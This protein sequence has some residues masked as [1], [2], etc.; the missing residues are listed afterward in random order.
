MMKFEISPP[1]VAAKRILV[2]KGFHAVL[3]HNHISISL[4]AKER[5]GIRAQMYL[6][7]P[8]TPA[9]DLCMSLMCLERACQD[10]C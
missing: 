1:Y 6:F 9:L 8:V 3:A 4:A 2:P 10:S 5:D 7:S